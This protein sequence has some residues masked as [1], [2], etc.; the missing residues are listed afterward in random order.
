M[1]ID[2][3]LENIT[4]SKTILLPVTPENYEVT[5]E[6]QIETVKLASAGDINV[7]TFIKP[8]AISIDGIFSINQNYKL[9]SNLIPELISNSIDY[10]NVLNEWQA[11]KDIIRVT[12]IP[13]GTADSR[14]DAKFYI[15]GLRTTGENEATG[16]IAY[17]ID[18]VEY[19]E[20]GVN[21]AKEAIQ[22]R[23]VFKESTPTATPNKTYTVVKG[24]SLYAIARKFYGNG[25]EYNKIVAANNIKNPNLIYPGQV[26]IIT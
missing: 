2:F 18:F 3:Y 15:Q 19:K 6:T 21:T 17:T 12:I 23:D 14:L 4:Q 5:T 10:V 25:N 8:K 26:F 16:D 24:D 13:R 7:P 22:Q 11:N 1:L 20:V 9:N